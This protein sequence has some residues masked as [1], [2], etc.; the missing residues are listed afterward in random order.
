MPNGRCPKCSAI[1]WADTQSFIDSKHTKLR[2]TCG[3]HDEWV[4]LAEP[5]TVTPMRSHYHL[6][7]L[8]C[9]CGCGQF[10][11]PGRDAAYRLECFSKR[12]AA[13]DARRRR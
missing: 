2:M 12:Q 9:K 6:P 8:P 10:V 5:E 4:T 7:P 13:R 1:Q 3:A 11:E